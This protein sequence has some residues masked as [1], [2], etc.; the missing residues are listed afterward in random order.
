MDVDQALVRRVARLA[1]IKVTDE[2]AAGLVDELSSILNFIEQLN[3]VDTDGVDPL[4]S[5]EK[6]TMKKRDDKV[7]DGG[8]PDRIVGNA[9][10]QE[11]HY[12]MVPKVVE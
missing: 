6:M 4:T 8:Y 1:R 3:E 5:V 2:E 7:T 10:M 9:P 12:F 11:D